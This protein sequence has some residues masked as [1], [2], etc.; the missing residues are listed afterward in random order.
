MTIPNNKVELNSDL[1]NQEPEFS[2]SP[3]A[4]ESQVNPILESIDA[5]PFQFA[6]G[7]GIFLVLIFGSFFFI[8]EYIQWKSDGE[9]I[10]NQGSEKNTPEVVLITKTQNKGSNAFVTTAPGESGSKVLRDTPIPTLPL[11]DV[12]FDKGGLPVPTN[13]PT[14]TPTITP[15]PTTK[16][17]VTPRPTTT[18]LPTLLPTAMA[19][20]KEAPV[21]DIFFP[22]DNGEI[23]Y[24]IDG[25]VCAI[26]DAPQDNVS[27]W[28]DITIFYAF[29][30][31]EFSSVK[32]SAYLC[33]DSIPNGPHTLRHKSQDKAGNIE[34]ERTVNF[35][36]N[37]PGN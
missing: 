7:I 3:F 36:V 10:Q 9:N 13:T 30:S 37:I 23:A 28:R 27:I 12:E 35:M 32:G 34:V 6:L 8:R 19:A 1:I 4:V 29:D 18:P 15:T 5:H 31:D 11:Q 33:K 16:A 22:L 21:V 17:T 20:D 2:K 26:A 25:K 24:K 14:N